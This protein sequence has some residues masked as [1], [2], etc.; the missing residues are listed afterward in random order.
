[1]T[2][3]PGAAV[4]SAA[5]SDALDR[6]DAPRLDR[7]DEVLVVLLVLVG[8]TL[9]EV[10]D[11]LV[12]RVAGAQVGGD[13]DWVAGTGVGAS[14]GPPADAGVE[15]EPERYH[16]LDHRRALHV[17]QLAPVEVAVHVNTLGP[18]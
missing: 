16:L 15:G 2:E 5:P 4:M 14:H 1:M 6:L 8:V 10:G 7:L 17:A 12:E 18:A 13:G 9:R 11:R 3:L